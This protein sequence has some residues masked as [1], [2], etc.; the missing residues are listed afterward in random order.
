MLKISRFLLALP[1]L[2]FTSVLV[3]AAVP[4]KESDDNRSILPNEIFL[5]GLIGSKLI[6]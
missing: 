2:F 1:V 4:V 3:I 5:Y 6:Q